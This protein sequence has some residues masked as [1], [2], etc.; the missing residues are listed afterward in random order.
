MQIIKPFVSDFGAAAALP[1]VFL[2]PGKYFSKPLGTSDL[3]I[4]HS[5]YNVD[6]LVSVELAK[7]LIYRAT[8]T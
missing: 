8:C 5:L 1:C 7:Y 4:C 3:S 6:N 2:P